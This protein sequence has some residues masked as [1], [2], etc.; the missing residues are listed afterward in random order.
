[1]NCLPDAFVNEIVRRV[2]LLHLPVKTILVVDDELANA[3]VLSLILEEE[4]YRVFCAG[5]GR[6]GL[7]R[8]REVQPDLVILDHLMPTMDGAEMA[9]EMRNVPALAR[10]P[11]LMNSSL[12]EAALRG[13][14]DRYDG[15]LRKPYSVDTMLAMIRELLDAGR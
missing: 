9:R 10:V 12:P 4:G 2:L 15:F 13:R 8:A 6:S 7:Q 5:N 3:E 14:Y 1:V 11:I